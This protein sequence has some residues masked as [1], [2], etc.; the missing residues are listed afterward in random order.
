VESKYG[1]FE[2][3]AELGDGRHGPVF[4]GLDTATQRQVVIRT[5]VIAMTEEGRER[6]LDAL[7]RLCDMPLDHAA[8]ASPLACGEVDGVPFL[9]HE[10]MPGLPLDE[11]LRQHGR[12]TLSDVS[13]RV[14]HLSGAID[15]AAA[16]GVLH[17]SLGPRDLLLED[18]RTG[19]AGFGIAQ[20]LFEAGVEPRSPSAAD[21]LYALAAMT[22]EML[23][24]E[25]YEGGDVRSA[26][27]SVPL[28]DDVDVDTL[29]RTLAATLSADP[30]GW[31]PSA[32]QFAAS[33]HEALLGPH[34]HESD[35]GP[36]ALDAPTAPVGNASAPAIGLEPLP[37]ESP[38]PVPAPTPVE[39]VTP[40]RG[41]EPPPGLPLFDAPM[42]EPNPAFSTLA[43][44]DAVDADIALRHEEP[45]IRLNP[46]REPGSRGAFVPPPAA[47]Q[48]SSRLMQL[49]TA[50]ALLV[51][52]VAVFLLLGGPSLFDTRSEQASTVP[53][54]P[55]NGASTTD[56]D[57]RLDTAPA[58]DSASLSQPSDSGRDL[59][60][61]A[62]VLSDGPIAERDVASAPPGERPAAPA[63]E[64]A[65]DPFA[66]RPAPPDAVPSAP[67]GAAP[68]PAP[69]AGVP[70]APAPTVRPVPSPVPQVPE[71]ATMGRVLVR[72][73][74]PG[75]QVFIDDELRGQTPVAVRELTLGTHTITVSAPGLPLWRQQ[76][77]LTAER[78][79]Q[80]F[81]IRL[82]ANVRPA[83]QP[84][85]AQGPATLQIESRPTGAQVWV[86]GRLVGTT[87]LQ[88]SGV[89]EGSRALRLELP[90]YRPW[91]T[92]VS[93]ARGAPAR[94]AASLEQ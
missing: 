39:P 71:V 77:T 86:D 14:T 51:A 45:G 35:A 80:S 49:G 89:E 76:V 33:I 5:F 69:A 7:T 24:G 30:S 22:Y 91:T 15:F 85:V 68:A 46:D 54:T 57:A 10:F 92:S 90:G 12:R 67:S 84:P 16:A 37:A 88:L 19:I 21:D 93:V 94:V 81:E 56:T 1:R 61:P 27:A 38:G 11:Y 13:L 75:A 26:L 79:A 32:L 65:Q 44:A 43:P 29:S 63:L 78:P 41:G 31:P 73:D 25:R 55:E 47:S 62:P 82:G 74:P 8:I 48:G 42:R 20:A 58:G 9:V 2:V 72:S 40:A 4:L 28:G 87:P 36:Q 59:F 17:G 70:A 50:A 18:D 6:F 52:A 3:T 23:V 64:S 83:A 60:T 66:A 53:S 34:G